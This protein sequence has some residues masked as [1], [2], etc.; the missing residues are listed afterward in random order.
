VEAFYEIPVQTSVRRAIREASA[1]LAS[2]GFTVDEFHPEGL[3]R[4]PNLWSFF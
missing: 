3:E 2:L 4:A 1:A